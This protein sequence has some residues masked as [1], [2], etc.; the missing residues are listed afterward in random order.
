MTEIV[1]I[2]NPN[3]LQEFL[4]TKE[5]ERAILT[6]IKGAPDEVNAVL[7]G[8]KNAAREM[9]IERALLR[10][11]QVVDRLQPYFELVERLRRILH[12]YHGGAGA[13]PTGFRVTDYVWNSGDLDLLVD[14]NG[15]RAD[16]LVDITKAL[17]IHH[18]KEENDASTALSDV[19]A[20]R[21]ETE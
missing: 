11:N 10:V 8:Q 2:M 19:F 7:Q 4:R 6:V 12:D 3:H 15:D 20:E 9:E 1:T 13:F 16:H 14:G 18:W 5:G 17:I 21:D